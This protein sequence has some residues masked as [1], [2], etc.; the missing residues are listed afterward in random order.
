M[1]KTSTLSIQALIATTAILGGWNAANAAVPEMPGTPTVT[2]Y[3]G[4]SFN[5]N[6]DPV[7]GATSYLLNV[8]YVNADKPVNVSENFSSVNHTNDKIDTANPNYPTGWDINVSTNGSTDMA[9]DGT[10]DYIVFDKGD[11]YITIPQLPGT[12]ES[13]TISGGVFDADR[14]DEANSSA[15]R[16]EV[17]DDHDLRI[18]S[19][20]VSILYFASQP[21]FDIFQALGY[22]T[23][24]ITKVKIS[25]VQNDQ[26]TIGK[27]LIKSVDYSYNEREYVVNAKELAE[28][29]YKVT[30]A[31]PLK[32]YYSNVA[33]KNAEG[34]STPSYMLTIDEFLTPVATNA[35]AVTATSYT[36]NWETLPKA[37]KYVVNN[38]KIT[39]V[40]EAQNYP[41]LHD[42]FA[43]ATEGTQDNPVSIDSADAY[44]SALGW[45]GSKMLIANGM[46]GADNGGMAGGRPMY[47]YLQTPN[48]DLSGNGGKYTVTIKAYGQE[49]DYLSVYRVGYVVGGK[50]NIHETKQFPAD[51]YIEE[52]WE[53]TDGVADMKLSI[54]PKN[55]KRF[56]LDEITISQELP[57]GSIVKSKVETVTV[58][59]PATSY[60]FENL[61][62]NGTYGYDLSAIRYDQWGYED[63]SEMSNTVTVKLTN[64]GITDTATQKV[65]NVNV[66]DGQILITT[67]ESNVPVYL[68]TID[69]SL[70]ATAVANQ[71]TT[72]IPV[73]GNSLYILKAGNEVHKLIVK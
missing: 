31:D 71:G 2:E 55:M 73:N 57:A 12:L 40:A 42:D 59:A 49:G 65:T 53:M 28:T 3:T 64:A 44:T 66:A 41:I 26:R 32:I 34:T 1:G 24:N 6:W 18:L 13:F 58:D 45:G 35:S 10:G 60:T 21:T 48:I 8:F 67:S 72:A 68:Y 11:D 39:E 43:K 22:N 29:S 7:D 63:T 14:I 69:G 36:A 56:F 47:G 20:D 51:G 30:G 46:L 52:S 38:Y 15:L 5:V 70:I 25:L 17:F 16:I 37:A 33:A 50:L 61:D 9:N 4:D 19:G 23:G 27:L 54:E 62:A